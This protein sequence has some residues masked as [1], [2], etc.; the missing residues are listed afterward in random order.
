MYT[1]V[2]SGT[3]TEYGG[4]ACLQTSSHNL[5][6]IL[7]RRHSSTLEPLGSR[8]LPGKLAITDTQI[9]HGIINEII[10]ITSLMIRV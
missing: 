7:P 9:N 4:W 2:E 8:L 6:A 3:W 5:A 10:R 1:V